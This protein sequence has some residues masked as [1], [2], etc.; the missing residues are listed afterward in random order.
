MFPSKLDWPSTR[1]SSSYDTSRSAPYDMFLQN[2]VKGTSH[3]SLG[4]EAV[5]AG[6]GAAMRPDDYTFATYRGH[7]H[8]LARGV[9][10][11]PVLAELLGRENGLLA[12]KGGSMHL[13]SVEH[14]MMDSY[15]GAGDVPSAAELGGGGGPVGHAAIGSFPVSHV[16]VTASA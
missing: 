12:G 14:G 15:A 3:L 2:L 8:T 13:T 7:A 1:S 16:G 4:M 11:G 6:F 10:M 5:A 9:P